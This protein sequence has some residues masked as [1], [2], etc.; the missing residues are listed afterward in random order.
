M[1]LALGIFMVVMSGCNSDA[2]GKDNE[3]EGDNTKLVAP[4]KYLQIGTGPMGSGWYPI[5]TIM[6]EI[7]MDNFKDLNASQI[8][9]GS[10]S[11][12]KSLDVE[13]IH[14][15]L[16]YTSDYA[17]ALAGEADF[18]EK[19]ETIAGVASLYPVFQTIAVLDSNKDI[20][21]IE[22]IVDK[23]I[24]LGPKTGGGP[25][26]FWRMMNEYGIDEDTIIKAG[27][28]L[29]YG[30]YNDGASMLTDNAID[31]YLGGGAPAVTALQE[32]E[33]TNKLRILPIDQDKLDSI[34][35]KDFGIAAGALP[36]GTYKGMDEDV[37]TYTTVAMLTV[38]KNLDEDYVYNLTKVFWDNQ[39]SFMAQ[40]PER[41][42]H[43]TLESIF[44][45]IDKDTLHPGAIKYYKEIG[46]FD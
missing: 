41:A 34:K 29:S 44:D 3:K 26:A 5:T 33:L 43:F 10:V 2:S 31:V 39:D 1:L 22:D 20:N 21:K 45:G 6:S 18:D 32:I 8:E 40:I 25:V 42:V 24:F 38:R 12:L 7:Y 23:H 14:M 4:E 36:A 28:K 9:G 37:P 27:G 17:D 19:L 35:D 30:S 15:A 11:N 13:D 16:N 46:K